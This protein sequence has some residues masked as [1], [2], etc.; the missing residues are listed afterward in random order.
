MKL[1]EISI[2]SKLILKVSKDNEEICFESEVVKT[3]S[4]PIGVQYGLCIS[5]IRKDGKVLTFSNVYKKVEITNLE[6]GRLYKF[7]IPLIHRDVNDKHDWSILLSPDD[8]L[9][10]NNRDAFRVP[11][12]EECVL[13]LGVNRK[14]LECYVRDISHNGISFSF[15]K[16]AFKFDAGDEFSAQFKINNNPIRVTGNIVRTADDE[17][18]NKTIVGCTLSRPYPVIQKLVN[19]LQVR[20]RT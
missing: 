20:N 3:V 4:N 5:T 1:N 19:K 13:Q 2:G 18:T 11:F 6:D 9:P 7:N 16:G 12:C 14:A 10:I 8:V 17:E 15:D